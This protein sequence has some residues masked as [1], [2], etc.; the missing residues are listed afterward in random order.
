MTVKRPDSYF[1]PEP[2]QWGEWVKAKDC[3]V[4]REE[5]EGLT[6]YAI[7]RRALLKTFTYPDREGFWKGTAKKIGKG[8][9]CFSHDHKKNFAAKKEWWEKIELANEERVSFIEIQFT[10]GFAAILGLTT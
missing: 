2:C 9:E 1:S 4:C 3:D 6:K 5:A 7:K 8:P 10:L